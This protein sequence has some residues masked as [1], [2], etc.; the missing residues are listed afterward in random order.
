MSCV[1]GC[2]NHTPTIPKAHLERESNRA[3]SKGLVRRAGWFEERASPQSESRRKFSLRGGE[4]YSVI[5]SPMPTNLPLFVT[6]RDQDG[7]S[8]GK[9]CVAGPCAVRMCTQLP[10]E[11]E[12]IVKSRVHAKFALGVWADR[13]ARGNGQGTCENPHRILPDVPTPGST[14]RGAS[15]LTGNC[16]GRSAPEQVYKFTLQSHTRVMATVQGGFD[17]VL[18]IRST[19]E[20]EHGELTCN[21]DTNSKFRS[22]VEKTLPPGDYYLVVDGAQGGSGSFELLLQQQSVKSRSQICDSAPRLRPSETMSGTTVGSNNDF[23]ASCGRGATSPDRVFRMDIDKPSRVRV[24]H[25]TEHD[26]VL[27]MRNSCAESSDELACVDDSG[28]AQHAVLRRELSP[29]SYYVVADGFG[30]AN[31]GAFAVTPEIIAIPAEGAHLSRECERARPLNVGRFH[32]ADSIAG[33]N[34]FDHGCSET[35]GPEATFRIEAPE[36]GI[37]SARLLD[38]D[39]NGTFSLHQACAPVQ[40]PITQSLFKAGQ[41]HHLAK[42]ISPGKYDVVVDGCSAHDFGRSKILTHFLSRRQAQGLC[43]AAKRLRPR[44]GGVYKKEGTVEP[45]ELTFMPTCADT[46]PLAQSL[47][48]IRLKKRSTLVSELHAPFA[49]TVHAVAS[50]E[51]EPREVFCFDGSEGAATLPAGNYHLVVSR[52][53]SAGPGRFELTLSP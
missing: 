17:A 13:S 8:Q 20:N 1:L 36:A 30:T 52:Y 28:D 26:G 16:G 38:V 50:C 14:A 29:G 23:S 4:C 5:A 31:G 35:S 2:A 10:G 46:L 18:S 21:D 32:H 41:S 27:H 9:N 49:A 51:G 22:R 37:L 3:L 48:T 44:R 7:V 25:H 42:S 43:K 19:C 39:H 40:K 24:K 6:V 12:T 45:R 47:Y 53:D 33:H 15:R 34:R 11:Y